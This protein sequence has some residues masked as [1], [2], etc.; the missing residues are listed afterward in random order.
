MATDELLNQLRKYFGH[1]YFR[2][3]QQEIIQDVMNG[4]DVLGILPTGVGKSL[5]FQ[6]PA[7]LNKGV[8]IVI[9]PLISLMVDQVKQLKA[10]GFKAVIAL[11]SFMDLKERSK[12]LKQLDKYRL[13]YLSPELLQ[14]PGLHWS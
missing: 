6:L 9:S 11:N 8:T 10:K 4:R 12:E 14:N 2:S 5:C 3:G 1:A 13:I 7:L